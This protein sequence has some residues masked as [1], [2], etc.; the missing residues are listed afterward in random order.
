MT[1]MAAD[2]LRKAT[3]GITTVAEVERIVPS[4]GD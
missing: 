3:E 4:N 2:G 1:T